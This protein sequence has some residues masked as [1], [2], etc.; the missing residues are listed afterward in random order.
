MKIKSPLT[1]KKEVKPLAEAGANEFFCGIEPTAWRKRFSDFSISQ[2]ATHA[3][4]T[5]FSDLEKAVSAAHKLKTKIHVAVNAFFYMEQHYE[6]A[7]RIIKEA[8]ALGVD[9]IIFADFGLLVNTPRA[10]LKDKDVVIGTDAVIF[11]RESAKFYK[12]LGATRLV[13]PR[14]VTI[15]EIESIV[16][17]DAAMEYEVFIIHDL[18]F[19]VDGF[20]TYCKEMSG[21]PRKE[22]RGRK[23]VYFFSSSRQPKRGFNGGCRTHF[24]RRKILQ[25]SGR[26]TGKTEDFTFWTKKHI[27]GCGACAIYDLK[28]MGVSSLKVLDRNLPTRGKIQATEFIRKSLDFL[29]NKNISRTEYIEKCKNLFKKTFNKKCNLYDCYY[30]S[31]FIH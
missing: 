30:P 27:Q 21:K 26:A 8:L 23:N 9:G 11:N 22:G 31:V 20:C 13:I 17:K 25:A 4:F 29:E 18:C 1:D 12:R 3:N 2:R 6:C 19:F 15:K 5:K 14:A 7:V 10:L 16:R 28:K 24:K